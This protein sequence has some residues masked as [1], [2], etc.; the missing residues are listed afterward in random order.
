MIYRY[1]I[2]VIVFNIILSQVV[3]A[4][5]FAGNGDRGFGASFLN[6]GV[7]SKQTA[8]GNACCAAVDDISSLYYNPAGLVKLY[9]TELGFTHVMLYENTAFDFVGFAKPTIYDFAYGFG[10]MSL[11]LDDIRLRDDNNNPVGIGTYR[12]SALVA[13]IAKAVNKKFSF[14]MTLKAMSKDFDKQTAGAV[15]LDAG[16]LFAVS[17]R[18]SAGLNVQNFTDARFERDGGYDAVPKN[19]KTGVSIVPVMS[20]SFSMMIT[21]DIDKN[22]VVQQIIPHAGVELTFAK[23]FMLR[24]GYDDG[25]VTAGIGLKTDSIKLDLA[26]LSHQALGT[27]QRVSLGF[28]FGPTREEREELNYEWRMEK[29][30]LTD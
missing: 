10:V 2:K 4:C 23:L 16:V 9:K 8:V 28:L 6:S 22:E 19:I 15:E 30:G 1:L 24:A 18:F 5:L 3:V 12:A 11:G 21:C 27:S 29:E 25:N 13:G 7:Y 20:D 14:G 26:V 17:S